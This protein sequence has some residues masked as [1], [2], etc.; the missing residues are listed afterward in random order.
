[1]HLNF[2]FMKYTAYFINP[3]ISNWSKDYISPFT[4]AKLNPYD[5]VL[6]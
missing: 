3:E 2:N 5:K 1:M 6:V 4:L